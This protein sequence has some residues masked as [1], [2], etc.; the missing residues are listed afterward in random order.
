[1]IT[2]RLIIESFFKRLK[3]NF[4]KNNEVVIFERIVSNHFCKGWFICFSLFYL[5]SIQVLRNHSIVSR[6][7]CLPIATKMAL[8][9]GNMCVAVCVMLVLVLVFSP[10]I[11]EEMLKHGMFF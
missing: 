7:V 4:S 8:Y 9:F 6:I 2:H 3:L 1:M 5:S 10:Q 11:E